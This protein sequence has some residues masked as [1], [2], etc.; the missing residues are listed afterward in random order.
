MA[1]AVTALALVLSGCTPEPE[2]VSTPTVEPEPE[3]TVEPALR[4]NPVFALSCADLF[5]LDD[6][7]ARVAAPI[8]IARDET[9]LPGDEL[10]VSYLQRGGLSCDWN[11]ERLVGDWFDGV[12]MLLVPDARADFE[13][14]AASAAETWTVAEADSTVASCGATNDASDGEFAGYCFVSALV[15]STLVELRFTDSEGA[16]TDLAQVRSVSRDLLTTAIDRVAA[17]GVQ[18][19]LWTAPPSGA[20]NGDLCASVGSAFVAAIAVDG[21]ALR[22]VEGDRRNFSLC[23]YQLNSGEFSTNVV[24]VTALHSG[25]W[26]AGVAHTEAPELGAPWEEHRT[27]AGVLWWLSPDGESVRARAAIDGDLVTISFLPQEVE[28]TADDARTVLTAFMEEYAEAPPG[29]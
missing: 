26:A 11:G 25:A 14:R 23:V 4:P 2:P 3:P 29:T 21:L 13:E 27:S 10:A 12:S 8:A 18:E 15:G 7:Q 16:Y 24:W 20:A 5:S 28:R 9:G 22:D 17:A 1:V 6:V 19:Q